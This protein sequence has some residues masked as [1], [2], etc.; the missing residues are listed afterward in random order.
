MFVASENPLR[1]S[2]PRLRYEVAV[3]AAHERLEET[4]RIG[5]LVVEIDVPDHHAVC[6]QVEGKRL[7]S[8]STPVRGPFAGG[9]PVGS[10]ADAVLEGDGCQDIDPPPLVVLGVGRIVKEASGQVAR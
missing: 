5:R 9:V 2:V 4:G 6:R 8:R 7:A 3:R 1:S 10:P